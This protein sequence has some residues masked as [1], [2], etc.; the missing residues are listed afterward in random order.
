[1]S[2]VPT[3][4]SLRLV[5]C[6]E[7]MDGNSWIIEYFVDAKEYLVGIDNPKIIPWLLVISSTDCLFVP[8][9]AF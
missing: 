5:F 8:V 7:E 6:K 9:E 4:L 3:E 1:M 2:K